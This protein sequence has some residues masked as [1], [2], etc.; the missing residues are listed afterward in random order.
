MS[1]TSSDIELRLS[2]EVEGLVRNLRTAEARIDG[3][4]GA[5]ARTS[6]GITTGFR[7]A[8]ANVAVIEGPL[9]GLAGRLNAL[10]TVAT[11]LANPFTALAATIGATTVAMVAMEK[12]AA[13]AGRRLKSVQAIIVATGGAAGKTATEV[14]QIS[15]AIAEDFGTSTSEIET[16]S[17]RILSF[18]RISGDTFERVLRL[19][20]DLSNLGF[21]PLE[22]VATDLAKAIANPAD[23]MIS[24]EE[25]GLFLTKTTQD[26]IKSLVEENDILGAQEIILNKLSGQV[27]GVSASM[28]TGLTASVNRLTDRWTRLNE[29]VGSTQNF[30]LANWAINKLSTTLN[31]F[32]KPAEKAADLLNRFQTEIKPNINLLSFF[33]KNLVGL[34]SSGKV[35]EKAVKEMLGTLKKWGVEVGDTTRIKRLKAE[36]FEFS[37]RLKNV[38]KSLKTLNDLNVKASSPAFKRLA[39]T[40]VR[41]TAIIAANRKELKLLQTV[42]ERAAAARKKALDLSIAQAKATRSMTAALKDFA[43]EVDQDERSLKA[44]LDTLFPLEAATRREAEAVKFLKDQ[45]DKLNLSTKD[46]K[47]ALDAIKGGGLTGGPEDDKPKD[48]TKPDGGEVFGPTAEDKKRFD[49]EQSSAAAKLTRLQE[50]FLSETELLRLTKVQELTIIQDALATGAILE[51]EARAESEKAEKRHTSA[52]MAL[53]KSEGQAILSMSSQAANALMGLTQGKNKQLF[54]ITKIASAGIATM[55]GIE[56]V[57]TALASP[58]GLALAIPTGIFAAANVAKILS[59]PFGGSGA[60][61]AAGAPSASAAPQ[62]SSPNIDATGAR[63]SEVSINLGDDDDLISARGVRKLLQRIDEEVRNGAVTG[64]QVV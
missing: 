56:A 21:G 2:A 44:L 60:S 48:K 12:A 11:G 64:I 5:A 41:L 50:S 20:Q 51:G 1:A 25:R 7:N 18:K 62:A 45:L 31:G 47:R 55:K 9:G 13:N 27:Q 23:E 39:D 3:L 34:T 6:T 17:A 53:K 8:A 43:S 52:M 16:V 32:L 22:S 19:S 24:L 14:R 58:A 36:I 61:A 35:N 54:A 46:Y 37:I 4:R 49:A 30:G 33:R 15:R 40:I 57:N 10:G 42:D 59:T 29:A 38:T 63:G 28:S 26:L